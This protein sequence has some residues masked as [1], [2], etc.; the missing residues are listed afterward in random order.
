[1]LI[2]STQNVQIDQVTQDGQETIT[3]HPTDA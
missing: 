3:V 2:A 1:M